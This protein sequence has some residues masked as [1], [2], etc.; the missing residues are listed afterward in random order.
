V[1]KNKLPFLRLVLIFSFSLAR[2]TVWPILIT[3]P[4]TVKVQSSWC[5]EQTVIYCVK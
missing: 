5:K 4:K 3:E 2:A 1:F